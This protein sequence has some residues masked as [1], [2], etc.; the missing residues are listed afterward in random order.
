MPQAKSPCCGALLQGFDA[1]NIWA[2]CSRCK[3]RCAVPGD[4]FC[5]KCAQERGAY[6]MSEKIP[7]HS[8]RC[9]K[10]FRLPSTA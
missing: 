9:P 7:N 5:G 8:L 6:P 2:F 4:W 3:K 10:R 1:S